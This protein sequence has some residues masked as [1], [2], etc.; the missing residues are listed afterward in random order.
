MEVTVG[1]NDEFEINVMRIRDVELHTIEDKGIQIS[2]NLETKWR[3][4]IIG[5]LTIHLFEE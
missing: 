2:A 1:Y 3:T 4:I 5:N